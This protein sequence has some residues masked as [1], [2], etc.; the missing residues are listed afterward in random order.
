M[1]NVRCCIR[2]DQSKGQKY[3]SKTRTDLWALICHDINVTDIAAW[4]TKLIEMI[5]QE[6]EVEQR[7]LTG[8]TC[9]QRSLS[10]RQE[11]RTVRLLAVM[12]NRKSGGPALIG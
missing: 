11:V 4:R 12:T 9:E 2:A 5:V 1:G 10:G 6:V 8:L 7:Q 3:A